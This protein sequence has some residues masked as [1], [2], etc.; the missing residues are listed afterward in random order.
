[1]RPEL[2]VENGNKQADIYNRLSHFTIEY[3]NNGTWQMVKTARTLDEAKQLAE[4]YVGPSNPV[5]LSE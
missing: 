5:F 2:V 4:S 1:M 3:Y